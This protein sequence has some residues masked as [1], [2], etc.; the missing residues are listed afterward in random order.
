MILGSYV[1]LTVT[2]TNKF[3]VNSEGSSIQHGETQARLAIFGSTK[4]D[5]GM[6]LYRF[7]AFEASSPEGLPDEA[8][9]V[10]SIKRVAKELLALRKAPTIEPYAGPAILSGRASGVFFHE[11][12]GHR[13]EGHRQ[14]SDFDGNTFTA[15]IDQSVLPSYFSVYDDPTIRKYGDIELS[16][17]YRFDDEG[18]RSQRVPLVQNGILKSFLLGRSP[19]KGFSKSNGHGRAQ[20]GRSPVSRQGNLLIQASESVSKAELR[21]LLI[22]EIKRQKKEFGL[23]FADISGGFTN[24]I[25]F[26]PQTFQVTPTIVYKVYA[27]GRPDELVRGLDLIGTPLTAFSKILAADNS[28]EIFNGI[29]GAESGLVPVSAIS[30]GVLLSQIEVQKRPK[31]KALPPILAPPG[32]DSKAWKEVGQ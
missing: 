3:F 4:A 22:A 15:K 19:I 29:C 31:S 27:D 20:P 12:F 13:V 23:F 2:A 17:F 25:R 9:I 5:D 26:A 30:P 32:V 14:K 1:S 24:T 28:P 8:R 16:G 18:I 21:K 10:S 6:D 7:E 11:I